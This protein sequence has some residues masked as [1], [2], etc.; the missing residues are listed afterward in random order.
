M[1][2]QQT[3]RVF[4]YSGL[5]LPDPDSSLGIE[6]VRQGVLLIVSGNYH[7]RGERSRIGRRKTG[8]HVQ[9]GGGD[10]IVMSVMRAPYWR[11]PP[12]GGV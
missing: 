1:Q 12:G 6:A 5:V 4:R 9:D 2:I 11:E 7:S 3:E 10:E 8:L